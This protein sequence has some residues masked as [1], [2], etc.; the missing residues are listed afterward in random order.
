[1]GKTGSTKKGE[2]KPRAKKFNL[3]QTRIRQAGYSDKMD[4]SP[5]PPECPGC[6]KPMP[7]IHSI[8]RLESLPELFVFYCAQCQHAETLWED[9]QAAQRTC[10]LVPFG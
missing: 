3:D 4:K 8:P 7:L 6:G 2:W 5:I 1:M 9:E 10:E